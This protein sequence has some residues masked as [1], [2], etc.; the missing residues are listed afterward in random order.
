MGKY[1]FDIDISNDN[2]TYTKLI[3]LTGKNKKVLEIGCHSGTLSKYLGNNGCSVTG[4]EIESNAANEAKM[5][6]NTL[7]EGNIESDAIFNQIKGSYEVILFADVLE[8]LIDP[9]R[10]LEKCRNLLIADGFILV[11]IP[12][13][14]HW[15]IRRNLLLGKF[16]Y[17]EFGLLD[18][19]HL[20]F[21]TLDTFRQFI[22]QIGYK[23]DHWESVP[24]YNWFDYTFLWAKPFYKHKNTWR[25]FNYI[26]AGLSKAFPKLFGYQFV[27]KLSP[28]RQ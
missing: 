25:F 14:A 17:Q 27:I 13:I 19:T 18:K 9:K 10:V 4:V 22:E 12:N 16:Q 26:E 3:R 23:I 15:S 24:N 11:S 7:I 5:N 21:Y 1:N 2:T 20:H 8:H 28:V 6:C